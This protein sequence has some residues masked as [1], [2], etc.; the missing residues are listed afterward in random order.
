MALAIGTL[1]SNRAV[2]VSAQPTPSAPDR[3]DEMNRVGPAAASNR[4]TQILSLSGALTCQPVVTD[5]KSSQKGATSKKSGS[6]SSANE[7]CDKR[8][9]HASAACK[10]VHAMAHIPT[11]RKAEEISPRFD[12]ITKA[13]LMPTASAFASRRASSL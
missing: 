11:K 12:W 2:F 6:F 9:C 3:I 8:G 10:T 5:E 7:S 13:L 1:N 4:E